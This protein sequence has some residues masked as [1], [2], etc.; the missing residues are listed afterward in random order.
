MFCDDCELCVQ[1]TAP[2]TI[3]TL[4]NT[5]NGNVSATFHD[6]VVLCWLCRLKRNEWISTLPSC[7]LATAAEKNKWQKRLISNFSLPQNTYKS[8]TSPGGNISNSFYSSLFLSN[9]T[10]C[11]NRKQ[12]WGCDTFTYR[13]ISRRYS[14]RLQWLRSY[15]IIE[16]CFNM[17]KGILK[18]QSTVSN[19]DCMLL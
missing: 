3:R 16:Q 9:T 19:N 11:S 6:T 15:F 17:M 2:F 4:M 12:M 10:F 18:S 1:E 5:S 7:P 8:P 14:I 13:H